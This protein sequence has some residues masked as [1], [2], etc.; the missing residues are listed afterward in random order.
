[1]LKEMWFKYIYIED[2]EINFLLMCLVAITPFFQYSLPFP[3]WS[4]NT[5]L[6]LSLLLFL[7]W[8]SNLKKKQRGK[9]KRMEQLF[10]PETTSTLHPSVDLVLPVC[11]TALSAMNTEHLSIEHYSATVQPCIHYTRDQ[12][13]KNT[14]H[15]HLSS[16][17]GSKE[18]RV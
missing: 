14:F 12:V 1:M 18:K 5:F 16:R 9:Q 6:P 7:T 2:A 10:V 3:T 15:L 17:Q 8:T 4:S 13:H 11:P